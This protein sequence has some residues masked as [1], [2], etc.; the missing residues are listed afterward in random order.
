MELAGLCGAS[1]TGIVRV[2]LLW[3]VVASE[4]AFGGLSRRN[5]GNLET[6]SGNGLL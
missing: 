4:S 5:V 1:T 2:I 3:R 6:V